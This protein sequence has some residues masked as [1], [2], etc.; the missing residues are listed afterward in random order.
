[1]V[2]VGKYISVSV[3]YGCVIGKQIC[4]RMS[5]ELSNDP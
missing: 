2:N 5:M 3:P 1:M 4:T